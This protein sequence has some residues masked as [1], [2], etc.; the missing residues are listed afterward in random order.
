VIQPRLSDELLSRSKSFLKIE[1]PMGIKNYLR[2]GGMIE[3]GILIVI[4]LYHSRPVLVLAGQYQQQ[5]VA[6]SV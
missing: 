4:D 1:G 2:F 5:I 6:E 3:E